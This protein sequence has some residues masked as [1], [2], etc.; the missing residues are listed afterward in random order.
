MWCNV[1]QWRDRVEECGAM[2]FDGEYS[3]G[4]WCDVFQ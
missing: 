2:H 4:M 1:F 3:R